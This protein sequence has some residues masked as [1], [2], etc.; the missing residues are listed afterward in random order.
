MEQTL[1]DLLPFK[2]WYK[3]YNFVKNI[4]KYILNSIQCCGDGDYFETHLFKHKDYLFYILNKY[5]KKPNKLF[6]KGNG[7]WLYELKEEWI[8]ID[9]KNMPKYSKES[10]NILINELK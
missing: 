8:N 1:T 7:T 6:K 10:Y 4:D 9:R 2:L 5:V 3:E